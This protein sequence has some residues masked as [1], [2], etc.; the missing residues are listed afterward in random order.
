MRPRYYSLVS[1]LLIGTLIQ[2]EIPDPFSSL[3]IT[4]QIVIPGKGEPLKGY[5]IPEKGIETLVITPF[6]WGEIHAGG[7]VRSF[8]GTDS[9]YPDF[10]SIYP[11][12]GWGLTAAFPYK[13]NGSLGVRIGINQMIFD[14]LSGYQRGESEVVATLSAT[15]S[16]PISSRW[17]ARVSVCRETTFTF[18]RIHLMQ[19]TAGLGYTL[20]TPSWLME[21]LE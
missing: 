3:E 6:Y 21:F 4:L 17:T 5:W 8:T 14:T 13:F 9:K 15:V 12:L 10:T 16:L 11:F 19:Y 20:H 18:K 2:G 1:F 7:Q